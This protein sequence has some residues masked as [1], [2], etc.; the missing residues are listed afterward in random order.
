MAYYFLSL[1]VHGSA[2]VR[3]PVVPTDFGTILL[4][5]MDVREKYLTLYSK[6]C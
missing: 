5:A 2:P 6:D 3:R 1:D 4:F